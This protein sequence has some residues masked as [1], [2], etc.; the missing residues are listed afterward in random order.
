MNTQR[1]LLL[2]DYHKYSYKR[3][4]LILA[5]VMSAGVVILLSYFFYRSIFAALPLSFTGYLF[6]KKHSAQLAK[7]SREELL[8]QFKECIM[9]VQNSLRAGYAV[10]NAFVDCR[11]DMRLL[12]G[13]DSYIY[14]ELELIRRGLVINRTL[15]GLLEDLA[16]RSGCEEILQFSDVFAIGKRSGGK[17]AE[18]I[19]SSAGMIAAKIDTRAEIMTVLSGRRL[20]QNIM[21]VIPFGILTYIGVS[22]P[23]YFDGLYHNPSG[24]AIMTVCL[25]IYLGAYILGDRI[26]E[27]IEKDM[28]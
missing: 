19:K 8:Q 16:K 20:E 1:S 3:S 25:A 9:T 23:G 11:E 17:L 7:R 2:Q 5:V 28:G 15:E 10:E 6:F 4:E 12:F 21:K 27:N 14:R 13:E 26:L 24:I 22:Y 18:I